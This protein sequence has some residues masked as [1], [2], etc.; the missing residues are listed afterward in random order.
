[1]NRL[2]L[3][4]DDL[5]GDRLARVTGLRAAHLRAVLRVS[6]GDEVKVGLLNDRIGTGL[7]RSLSES[8]AEI[9]FQLTADPP[10]PSNITVICAL[11][12]PKF[13]KRIVQSVS[14]LGIKHAIFIHSY[15]V[16]KVYWSCVQLQ[17]ASVFAAI[18][19][20]LEF[21]GDTAMPRIEFRRRF[22]PFIEDEAPLLARTARAVVGDPR[23]SVDCPRG[24]VEPAIA[25]LGPEGGFIP[26]EMEKWAE[27]GFMPVRL[28]P[29]VLPLETAIPA[30]IGRLT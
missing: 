19:K 10:S 25:A 7:I 23:A 6:Q 3:L 12:R 13:F 24:L 21:A 2:L 1:M 16:E 8:A 18:V 11:P 28:G 15:K 27:A 17:P 30:L 29:R 5:I 9:E 4:P 20:G 26:Y 14:A 22:K